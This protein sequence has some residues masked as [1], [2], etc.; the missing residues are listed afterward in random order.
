LQISENIKKI[1]YQISTKNIYVTHSVCKQKK[2]KNYFTEQELFNE[3]KSD[4]GKAIGQRNWL[5]SQTKELCKLSYNNSLRK[6]I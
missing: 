5:T 4:C 2:H 3:K 6:P 1:N